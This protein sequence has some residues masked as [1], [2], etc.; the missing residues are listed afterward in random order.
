[1]DGDAV[2]VWMQ[3]QCVYAIL[4]ADT[5]FQEVRRVIAVPAK[6]LAAAGQIQKIQQEGKLVRE[7]KDQ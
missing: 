1:M 2:E 3:G 6:A 5:E 4:L 7:R